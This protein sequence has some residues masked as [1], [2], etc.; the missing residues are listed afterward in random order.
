[1]FRIEIINIMAGNK[2]KVEREGKTIL[3][4]GIRT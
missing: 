1:M 2:N 3:K 4:K